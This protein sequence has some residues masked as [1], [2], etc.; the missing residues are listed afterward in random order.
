M[1]NPSHTR[2]ASTAERLI[3]K[4]GATMTLINETTTGPAYDPVVTEVTQSVIAVR[5]SFS[6]FE[7]GDGSRIKST[8]IKLL[9]SSAVDPNLYQKVDGM[10]I[11]NAE[12]IKPGD[13]TIMYNV[14]AR[15]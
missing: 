2:L 5:L 9:M 13:V 8:D 6:D 15:L 11:I 4:H 14:Q 10:Q 3:K 12:V 7:V 1:P